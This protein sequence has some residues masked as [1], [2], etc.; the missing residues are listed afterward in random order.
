MGHCLLTQLL[1]RSRIGVGVALMVVFS[2]AKDPILEA[3]ESMESADAPKGVPPAPEEGVVPGVPEEPEPGLPG[4]QRE[5]MA[6]GLAEEPSPVTP[7]EPE[8]GIPD[9]PEPAPPGTDGQ[10]A[11]PPSGDG[12]AVQPEPGVPDEPN[13]A[14]PGSPG[15]ADHAGKE[16]GSV[17]EGP[18]VTIRGSISFA[19]TEGKVRIDLF[20]GDQRN[21]SGPRPKV[22]GVHE[23]ATVGPFELSVPASVGSVWL[24]A[25]L[26]VNENNRPDKGE[27]SGWYSR[28]PVHLDDIPASVNIDLVEEGK[29][30][31]LG[32]DFGE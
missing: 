3:A 30:T 19:A 26:D 32:L 17:D 23:L 20:D 4:E 21:V 15:G 18:H 1:E 16:G 22:V 9:E 29:R 2:C 31:G 25:Y 5:E 28:N 8:P 27:P 10:P 14:P 7:D 6:K 12:V 11:P 24:G 13:P